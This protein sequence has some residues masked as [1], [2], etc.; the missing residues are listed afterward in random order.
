MFTINENYKAFSKIIINDYPYKINHYFADKYVIK[1]FTQT[2]NDLLKQ[3]SKIRDK[4]YSHQNKGILDLAFID[5]FLIL[6]FRL[7]FLFSKEKKYTELA[8]AIFYSSRFRTGCNIFYKANI[9]KYFWP[10]HP[11]GTNISQHV[12]FGK[13]LQIYHNVTIGPYDLEDPVTTKKRTKI[14]IGDWV[15]VFGNSKIMGNS[16]IGDNVILGIGSKIVNRNVPSNTTVITTE[17]GKT[18]FLPN[19]YN[20]K[21]KFFKL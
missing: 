3:H 17:N 8:K 13:G 20:N 14:K 7:S 4:Y 21:K 12:R 11:Y 18:I 10:I 15:I 5:H 16:V 6:T 1:I 2:F 9:N 19:K